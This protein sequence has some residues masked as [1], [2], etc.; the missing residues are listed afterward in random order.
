MNE[1]KVSTISVKELKERRDKNATLCL[2]DVREP[3]EWDQM[4][5]P[6]ATLIPKGSLAAVIASKVPNYDEPIY[7]HCKGGVRS[8]D[9]ANELI[10]MGYKEVYSVEG[11]ILE[12]AMA[13]YPI[14]KP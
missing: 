8:F 2:I 11:G 13:G 14:E 10:N 9:A 5:I 3:N 6:G 12:W 7:L 1:H 4:H